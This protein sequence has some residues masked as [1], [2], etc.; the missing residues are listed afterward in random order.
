MICQ[1]K[2]FVKIL[3]CPRLH[4]F[5]FSII[6][7]S[8]SNPC[9]THS[10]LFLL[11]ESLNMASSNTPSSSVYPSFLLFIC[12][13]ALPFPSLSCSG[14]RKLTWCLASLADSTPSQLSVF[15]LQQ[16]LPLTDCDSYCLLLSEGAGSPG[17]GGSL[18]L[19]A[20]LPGVYCGFLLL[21]VSGRTFFLFPLILLQ[22]LSA[23]KPSQLVSASL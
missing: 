2:G 15:L 7:N 16:T 18:S 13:P 21:L 19:F 8:S 9:S 6:S 11:R 12:K 5:I 14:L 3:Q 22:I 10:Y 17:P 20:L 4:C 23:I 1:E